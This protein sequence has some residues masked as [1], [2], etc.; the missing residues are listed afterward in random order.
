MTPHSEPFLAWLWGRWQEHLEPVN[1][2]NSSRKHGKSQLLH[3]YATVYKSVVLYCGQEQ[4]VK[5]HGKS[6]YNP[7]GMC[8]SLGKIYWMTKTEIITRPAWS[9][10]YLNAISI[11]LLIHI[12]IFI[13]YMTC[14]LGMSHFWIRIKKKK[15]RIKSPPSHP[16]IFFH[17]SRAWSW[18]SSLP[19][20][21]RYI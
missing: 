4:E 20:W 12:V 17:L 1:L 13:H 19:I 16:P 8:N 6:M 18:G 21:K 11:N 14:I 10:Q 9:V 3:L 5:H 15:H 7:F 2:E